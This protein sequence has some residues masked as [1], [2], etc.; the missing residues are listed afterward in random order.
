MLNTTNYRK[1][2]GVSVFNSVCTSCTGFAASSCHITSTTVHFVNTLL[3]C[4]SPCQLRPLSQNER[5]VN[6]KAWHGAT[7]DVFRTSSRSSFLGSSR[8][9]L[10]N[11]ATSTPPIRSFHVRVLI[12]MSSTSYGLLGQKCDQSPKE[13]SHRGTSE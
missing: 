5:E 6:G 2:F 8:S 12:D 7:I 1:R 4:V 3:V 11:R 9:V 13:G 10:P